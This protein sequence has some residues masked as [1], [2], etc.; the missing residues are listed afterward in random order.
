[1]EIRGSLFLMYQSNRSLNIPPTPRATP[2][3]LNFWKIFVQIPHSRGQ[4]AVQMP[5]HRS[6]S[7]DQMPPLLGNFS[8]AFIMLQKLWIKNGFIENK[9]TWMVLE[10]LQI[11]R[12]ACA[13]LCFS[14]SQPRIGVFHFE[15]I[16]ACPRLACRTGVIF[17]VFQANRGGGECV[18]RA[19]CV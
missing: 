7:G 3:H 9:M 2:G 8:V 10:C 1:M 15:Y 5:H 16:E 12:K 4:K 13:S 11:Q 14:A 18:A 17:C 19:S 6:I